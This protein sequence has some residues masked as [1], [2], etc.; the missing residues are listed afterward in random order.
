MSEGRRPH[1]KLYAN[2]RAG[3]NKGEWHDLD[4]WALEAGIR[5]YA[6]TAIEELDPVIAQFSKEAMLLLV[7]GGDGT[8]LQVLNSWGRHHG[9][10]KM[11]IVVPVG[12]GTIKR[13]RRWAL[14]NGTPA[15][16]AMIALE[17]FEG[18]RL[19]YLPLPLLKV[20]WGGNC[21]YAVT[22]MAGAPVRIM[23]KYSH[24]KTTPVIAGLF[25]AG[26][27]AAAAT[28]R[29]KFF[30]DLFGQIRATVTVD[31][32]KLDNEKWIAV[33]KDVLEELIFSIKPYKGNCSPAQ[34]FS[35]AYAIDYH[36]TARKFLR[37]AV[38]WVPKGDQRYF[39]QPTGTI[40]I[41]PFEDIPFTLDGDYF[42][43]KAGET[44]T[45]SQGPE[46][47]VAVNP[48]FHLTLLRRVVNQGGRIKEVLSYVLPT[49]RS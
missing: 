45:V 43:A 19:P 25:A 12:G 47:K 39:N 2:R 40:K 48:L 29:P 4:D 10:E 9:V 31:G 35:L 13:L 42:T 28:G 11:P 37:L 1:V 6:L 30:T 34:S 27:L 15:E 20:E 26:A 33:I 49:P 7:F 24:F 44:I 14:W 23:Q 41:E 18:K 22:F 36:E 38:G 46:V 5:S 16:N 3:W 32:E 8:M 21:Y 17:L